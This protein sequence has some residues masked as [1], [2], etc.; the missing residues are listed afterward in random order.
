MCDA[1]TVPEQPNCSGRNLEL[2]H[3]DGALGKL[4]SQ[5]LGRHAHRIGATS[6]GRLP[7]TSAGSWPMSG[8]LLKHLLRCRSI[9]L[10][11]LS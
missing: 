8:P 1:L 9:G 2:R 3:K 5:E 11:F 10:N 7:S 6:H 4:L